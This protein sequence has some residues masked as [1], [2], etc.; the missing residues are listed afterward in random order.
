VLDPFVGTGTTSVAAARWGRDS[1]GLELDSSYFE[2]TRR[3]LSSEL[4]VES[5]LATI[6]VFR[7][8][9]SKPVCSLSTVV[10]D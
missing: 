7:G 3:R 10:H 2:Q 4:S 1:H 9:R 5:G 6:E 8:T